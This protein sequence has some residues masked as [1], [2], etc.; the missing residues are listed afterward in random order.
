MSQFYL[1][2]A[3]QV[4][5]E[6]RWRRRAHLLERERDSAAARVAELADRCGDVEARDAALECRVRKMETVE[7]GLRA[8]LADLQQALADRT[9]EVCAVKS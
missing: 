9:A 1:L 7:R 8:E 4:R 5:C 2:V 6:S 3:V